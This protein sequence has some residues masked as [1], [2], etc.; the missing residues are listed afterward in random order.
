MYRCN[1]YA[2]SYPFSGTQNDR[3]CQHTSDRDIFQKYLIPVGGTNTAK[4]RIESD[5]VSDRVESATDSVML[6]ASAVAVLVTTGVD[7]ES[8]RYRQADDMRPTLYVVGSQS[9]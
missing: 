4:R 7:R 1:L 3:L 8:P 2:L 9:G 6:A 5:R